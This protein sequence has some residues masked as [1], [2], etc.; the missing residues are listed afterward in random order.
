MGVYRVCS[1]CGCKLEKGATCY[2]C[3]DR[4]LTSGVLVLL[5]MVAGIFTL[6]L[7]SLGMVF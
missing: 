4:T 3:I 7:V 5:T 1:G 2:R 6:V